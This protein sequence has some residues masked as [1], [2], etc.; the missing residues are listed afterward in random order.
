MAMTYEIWYRT[1]LDNRAPSHVVL[2]DE[3]TF[4]GEITADSRSQATNQL[5][6]DRY[7]EDPI[8]DGARPLVQGD[9]L[10]DSQQTAWIIT[11]NGLIA[12]VEIVKH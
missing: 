7:S 6:S 9:L 8:F 4:A 11:P 1:K 2:D 10:I 12:K 5:A 3:Y